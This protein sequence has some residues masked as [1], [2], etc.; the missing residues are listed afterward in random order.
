MTERVVRCDQAHHVDADDD[1][2]ER[3]AARGDWGRATW[4]ERSGGQWSVVWT[5]SGAWGFY[6]PAELREV[7]SIGADRG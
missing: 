4:D 2:R 1:G 3:W 5:R 6:S 7:A